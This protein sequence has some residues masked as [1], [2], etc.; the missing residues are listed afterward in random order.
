MKS[1][2]LRSLFTLVCL[3]LLAIGVQADGDDA[4]RARL[5]LA[6]ENRNQIE[7]AWNS[8]PADQ[9]PGLEFLLTNMPEKDL[10]QLSAEFLLE[11]CRLAYAAWQ[12]TPWRS[13]IDEAMF[14][15]EILPYAC[16]NEV[17]DSWRK[18][19]YEE[20]KPVVADCQTPGQAAVRLNQKI[21]SMY[22]VKYST[23]RRKAIQ[24]PAESMETGLASCSGLS[25]LLVDACRAVGVPARFVGVP[26]WTDNSGN[27]SW[28]EI[29]DGDWKFTGAAEPN[30]DQLNATW[31]NGR[32]AQQR[33]DETLY[34][35]YAASFRETPVKFPMFSRR[36]DSAIFAVNVTDR[37][38]SNL[39][40][41]SVDQQWLR[42]RAVDSK[43]ERRLAVPVE[44]VDAEGRVLG[45]GETKDERFDRNDHLSLAIAKGQK[46]RINVQWQSQ[47]HHRE[48]TLADEPVLISMTLNQGNESTD[49]NDS[50]LAELK[51]YLE[52][53]R[54]ARPD[55][56]QQ[57]FAVKALTPAQAEQAGQWLW[58]DFVAGVRETRAAEMES[59]QIEWQD[60]KMPF[61]YSVHGT[62]PAS[63]RRLF[64][65]MHGG[66]EAPARVNDRQWENQKKLYTPEEGV[67]LAPRA[68]TDSWNMWH[69]GHI[70]PLYDR[71]ISNLIVF[72]NV[73][74]DCVYLLGYS[75]GGDGVYQV[76]PRMADRFAAAAMMAGHPNE[77]QP[78][79]LRNLPFTIH[80]GAKDAAFQRNEVAANWG[81]RLEELRSEDPEG[82]ESFTKLHEGKG[83]WMDRQD[84]E[85]IGWLS[86]KTRNVWPKKIVW[87]QD[88]VTHE[89]FYWLTLPPGVAQ[90]GLTI[91][92][93]CVGQK[94]SI[95]AP[96]GT[97]VGIRLSGKL[98]DLSQ[99]VEIVI[100][101]KT[102]F[103]GTVAA[104]IG[105]MA[106]S[107]RER[108]DPASMAVAEWPE[109][110][111]NK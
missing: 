12:S 45:Q 87:H 102:V 19:F 111:G 4:W 49:V 71:L 103:K 77:A 104:K 3:W 91:R 8:I 38:T 29:W 93:E 54:A 18:K 42:I 110:A 14:F 11:N 36:N 16:V 70:D 97:P 48:V 89:R 50:V 66:G 85:A 21:F 99:P 75:A 95:V 101:D 7:L 108:G 55:I 109:A 23:E 107:L 76:A 30:G 86:A 94:I 32:A 33:R 90:A 100:N 60:W 40:A 25:I 64:I 2:S 68:P 20:L 67:Y 13:Q 10:R 57:P 6:G 63:G 72:E 47:T 83:H 62:A 17:R 82:Y 88:D 106:K 69:Q 39:Q 9:R 98:V 35:I 74:P 96:E 73:N 41:L 56:D 61:A 24:S 78:L 81:K 15:N 84:G 31:F 28:V 59:K 52:L 43:T 58:Q 34:A 27:H 80:M 5:E 37:Y 51:A 92:A 1:L 53:P 65:S 26:R 22:Q 105:V 46:V 44:I 79:S